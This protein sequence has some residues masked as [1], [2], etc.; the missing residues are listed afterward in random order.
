MTP[1]MPTGLSIIFQCFAQVLRNS[2]AS[3]K[4]HISSP[5]KVRSQGFLGVQLVVKKK[6]EFRLQRALRQSTVREGIKPGK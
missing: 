4:L 6:W 5:I 2:N 1:S 3:H